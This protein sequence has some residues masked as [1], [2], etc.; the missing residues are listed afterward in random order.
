MRYSSLLV[1]LTLPSLP[2]TPVH[3][4]VNDGDSVEWLT[5]SSELVVLGRVE[6]IVTTSGPGDFYYE[7]CTVAVGE[8]IQGGAV[9]ERVTFCLR[10][11]GPES[12]VRGW[13]KSRE[14]ILH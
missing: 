13:M 3:A 4:E 7:D 1:L 2:S 5:C 8:V 14:S 10:S 11:S 6:R 12:R 9:G